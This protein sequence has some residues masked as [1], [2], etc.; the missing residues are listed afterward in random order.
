MIK[1]NLVHTLQKSTTFGYQETRIMIRLSEDQK[2]IFEKN[3]KNITS[4]DEIGVLE[5]IDQEI[6]KLTELVQKQASSKTE[7]LIVNTKLLLEILRSKDFPMT[8]SSRKWIVF[9][10][11]YLVSDIDLIPD[12]I[13]R[14]GYLDDAMV[15]AW[16]KHLV[17]NDITRYSIFKKAKNIENKTGII[18]KMLQGDGQTEI[19]LIPGF[20]SS[21]LNTEKYK[22]WAHIIIQSKLGKDK[23][24]ISI[25]DWKTNYTPEFQNTI[26]MIDH[27]LNLKP[28]YDSEIFTVDWQ[29]LKIDYTNLSNAFFVGIEELKKQ[30]PEKKIIVFAL[31]IGTYI[32]DNNE[33]ANKLSLIDDYYIFGG[34]SEP[35]YVSDIISPKVKNIYNFFNYQDAALKFIFENFEEKINPVGLAAI[36]TAKNSKLKNISVGSQQRQHTDYK[37]QFTKLIDSV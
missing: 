8:E 24:G 33:L 27:E 34:C 25:L 4:K 28:K 17:D 30:S 11:N 35:K 6:E 1:D 5:N 15:V 21:N 14:I 2:T 37:E 7:E 23:P 36:H 32:I 26:L 29:Q 31:N 19:I 9:G 16:V 22:Q 13:P 3:V 10:L 12:S 20:L 18:K